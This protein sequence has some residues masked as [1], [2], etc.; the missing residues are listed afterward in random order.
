MY[1]H[2]VYDLMV[3]ANQ[4]RDYRCRVACNVWKCVHRRAG[5]HL[6]E[7]GDLCRG[8]SHE[9]KD[10]GSRDARGAVRVGVGRVAGKG[11]GLGSGS[12]QSERSGGRNARSTVGVGVSWVAGEGGGRGTRGD[13]RKVTG[14]GDALDALG[15]LVGRVAHGAGRGEASGRNE[16]NRGAHVVWCLWCL[17]EYEFERVC[18]SVVQEMGRVELLKIEEQVQ[19]LYR[20]SLAW[21]DVPLDHWQHSAQDTIPSWPT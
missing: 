1:V 16:S 8:R 7:A 18:D 11:G 3:C 12:D 10:T 6:K 14:S 17:L 4:T 19:L 9:R 5:L 21:L 13:Q 2:E 20:T 15:V